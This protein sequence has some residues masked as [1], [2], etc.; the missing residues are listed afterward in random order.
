M[1]Y[2]IVWVMLARG[3]IGQGKMQVLLTRAV[4][5]RA[6]FRHFFLGQLPGCLLLMGI[7][8]DKQLKQSF[9]QAS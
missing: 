1:V 3:L 7:V 5:Q 2:L 9:M 8:R 6:E 4:W